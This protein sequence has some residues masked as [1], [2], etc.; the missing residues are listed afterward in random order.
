MKKQFVLLSTVFFAAIFTLYSCQ[1]DD[2][3]PVLKTKTQLLTQGT[4]KYISAVRDG[5]NLDPF[6]QPCQKDNII[7]LAAAGTGITDEGPLK[8]NAA[9][10]QTNPF[11]WTFQSGETML[12][13]SAALIPGGST[14]STIVTLSETQL[15]VSQPYTLAGVTKDAVVTFVH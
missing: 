12:S 1:P 4:W 7:T 15:I 14:V 13:T 2:N 10:P 5:V 6:L 3:L 8:C 11:T 9:D